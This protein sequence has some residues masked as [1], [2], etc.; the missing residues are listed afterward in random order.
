MPKN[1]NH[2]G[3][4]K[5]MRITKTGKIRHRSANHKHLRSGKGG[6]RLRQLR[7]HLRGNV[8]FVRYGVIV[9]DDGQSRGARCGAEVGEGLSGVGLVDHRGEDHQAVG[10]EFFHFAGVAGGGVVAGRVGEPP[11]P[12]H[13]TATP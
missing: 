10:A 7:K 3:L 5:R 2:K 12:L 1:K 9:D 13:A 11:Q 4:A 8:D 6:K